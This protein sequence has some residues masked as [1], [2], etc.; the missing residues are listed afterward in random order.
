[1]A[2]KALRG[3]LQAVLNRLKV[4]DLK[5]VRFRKQ[6]DSR[7]YVKTPTAPTAIPLTEII[8]KLPYLFPRGVAQSLEDYKVFSNNADK[9]QYDLL[10]TLPFFP[11][12][13]DG[14][15]AEIVRT[16]IDEDDNFI[17]EFF[18]QPANVTEPSKLKHLIF[19]HGYG[20]GLGFFLK[21]FENIQLKDNSWCIHAIDLPGFGFSSRT[22]FPFKYPEDDVSK[23]QTW[24]HER[25]KIWFEKRDLLKN[26]GNNMVVAH[27]LGAYL[28]ALYK[29]N[30][31][32]HFKKLIMC[33][34]AGM[35]NSTVVKKQPPW[36]YAALWD[37]NLSPFSLVRNS[38]WLGSKLTSGWSYRR[39]RSLHSK[40]QF[41]NLHL[42]SYAIFNRPGCG[43]YLLAFALRCGGDP[44]VSLEATLF[45]DVV[46]KWD[47]DSEWVWLYGDRDWMDVKGGRRISQK[48]NEIFPG[49]SS[50]E[51]IPNAGHHLYFDNISCFNAILEKEM[52]KL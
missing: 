11:E 5:N 10:S 44:R 29:R 48:I 45:N 18:I 51:V 17:N 36:W 1:M 26:P 41:E 31:P 16:K 39:F 14:K 4:F 43:E 34:P 2:S 9:I 37:M 24:F 52:T 13:K 27:S 38:G 8:V 28:M 40:I 25:L 49:K 19:I 50:V 46:N 12:A 3:S 21:N 33:S 20:A 23:V 47:S 35:C 30:N 42:Y 7:V 15:R 22:K 32:L 6:S